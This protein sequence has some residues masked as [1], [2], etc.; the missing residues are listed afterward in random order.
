MSGNSEHNWKNTTIYILVGLVAYLIWDSYYN[1]PLTKLAQLIDTGLDRTA[2][3]FVDETGRFVT[4][5]R[6]IVGDTLIGGGQLIRADE[7][8]NM[9]D[10]GGYY[11]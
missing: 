9:E 1:D 6:N 10:I 2:G 3:V 4:G 11:S 5:S 8:D 7:I